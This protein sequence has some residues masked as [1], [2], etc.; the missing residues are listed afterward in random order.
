[1]NSE[2]KK[3]DYEDL[4]ALKELK[5]IEEKIQLKEAYLKNVNVEFSKLY[6]FFQ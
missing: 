6:F 2:L 5:D 1:M 4:R 3:G